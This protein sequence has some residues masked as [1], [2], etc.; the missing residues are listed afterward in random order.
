M[1]YKEVIRDSKHGFTRGK[2]CLT[3]LMTFSGGLTVDKVSSNIIY[4]DFCK[5]FDTIPHK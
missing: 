4:V 5:A 2:F 1:E 3:D